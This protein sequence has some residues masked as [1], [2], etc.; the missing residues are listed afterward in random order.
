MK[1]KGAA[2]KAGGKKI[3]IQLVRSPIACIPAHRATVRALG[4]RKMNAIV[5]HDASPAILGMVK[6]VGYLLAVE[7]IG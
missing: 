5:E 6:A 3:R 7:E 2:A 1:E 4:L